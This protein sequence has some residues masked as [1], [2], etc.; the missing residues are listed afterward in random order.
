MSSALRETISISDYLAGELE[1]ETK[2]EYLGGAVYA[3]AGGSNRH[4]RIATDVI[5]SLGGQLRGKPCQV[6][7]SDTKIRISMPTHTRFY[8]PDASVTCRPNP[9]SD[10]F[11]DDPSVIVEVLSESTCRTDMLEKCEAYLTIPK[12]SAYVMFE[13]HEKAAVCYHRMDQG[14]E[15]R[16]F[17]GDATLHLPAVDAVLSLDEI[18]AGVE[19][20]PLAPV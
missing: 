18:Y 3:M 4:N 2:H 14:F 1:S 10:S 13:Q 17:T 12:L 20:E 7:H 19:P 8:Y 11:Q 16:L 9:Q 15:R 6:F 5:G